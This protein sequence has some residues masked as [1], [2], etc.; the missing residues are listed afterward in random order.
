MDL[1][2]SIKNVLALDSLFLLTIN[3]NA[4]NV[5]TVQGVY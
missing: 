2:I 1:K 4:L 3:T 5:L